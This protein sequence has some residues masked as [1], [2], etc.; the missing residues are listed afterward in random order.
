VIVKKI[1]V[2]HVSQLRRI[3]LQTPFDS[4]SSGEAYKISGDREPRRMEGDA[5]FVQ[6]LME[7]LRL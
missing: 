5:L 2:R 7:L 4:D 1:I 3:G 6:M